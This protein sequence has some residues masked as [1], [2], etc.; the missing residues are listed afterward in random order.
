MM[1]DTDSRI[2][3]KKIKSVK[4]KLY[5]AWLTFC[6]VI[7]VATGITCYC[8]LTFKDLLS[9]ALLGMTTVLILFSFPFFRTEC[10]GKGSFISTKFSGIYFSRKTESFDVKINLFCEELDPVFWGGVQ[11]Y[12]F[13][14]YQQIF[15]DCFVH[16]CR[17]V[18]SQNLRRTIRFS[19]T[20]GEDKGD[21]IPHQ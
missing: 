13:E 2:L 7:P 14:T 8:F 3:K 11:R 17:T 21:P 19:W 15:H 5:L 1:F 9:L 6:F 18:Y 16:I 10:K 20:G 12:D 4:S